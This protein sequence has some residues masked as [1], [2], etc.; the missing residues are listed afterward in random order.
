MFVDW[1]NGAGTWDRMGE[2]ARLGFRAVGWKLFQ[3]V[4]SL[5]TDRTDRATYATIAVPTLL[6]GG[7]R[8]PLT[9]RRVVERLGAALPHATV[10]VLA[11][12]GHMGP[13]SHTPI[14]N[15]AIT[16]HLERWADTAQN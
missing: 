14:V 4:I 11:G 7:D 6:L 13:I 3:E 5:T 10:R 2:Q 1:W 9:E 16:A 8:T 15:E 12:A